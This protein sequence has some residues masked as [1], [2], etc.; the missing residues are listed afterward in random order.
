MSANENTV[1]SGERYVS[2][3]SFLKKFARDLHRVDLN[4]IKR[5][6]KPIENLPRELQYKE[7]SLLCRTKAAI[8]PEWLHL[9]GKIRTRQM[10]ETIAPTFSE[11]TKNLRSILGTEYHNFVMAHAEKLDKMI[12]NEKD[13]GFD[14]FAIEVLLKSYLARI[15]KNGTITIMESPQYMYLRIATFLWF[16]M[17]PDDST[18]ENIQKTYKN[19]SDGNY[20]CASPTMFNTGMSRPQL[21]SCF[22]LTIDDSMKSI[23]KSWHD[24]ATIS[25]HSGGIGIDFTSLRH[26]EIGQHGQTRGIVPWIK[27]QAEILKTVD[28]GG[29]RS[30]SATVYLCDWHLDIEEFLD[31]RKGTGPDS[32]RARNLFYALW[33]SDEFMRRVLEDKEWT[34][35]CPNKVRGLDTKWGNEFEMDYKRYEENATKGKIFHHRVVRARDLW[36][37]IL[38]TQE[39]VGMPFIL[40]KDACNRK[41]NQKN[42]GTIRLSNLCT[43]ILLFTDAENIGSCNLGSVALNKCVKFDADG[44]PYY[45]FDMLEELTRQ[46]VRIVNQIIDRNFYPYEIPE[47]EYTNLRNRPIGIG[48][49]GLA[50]VFA[51]MDM[52]WVD[53]NPK[54]L[55]RRIIETMYYAAVSESV[56]LAEKYGKYDTFDG[57]PASKGFFQFDLWDIEKME[58]EYRSR[59][60][61]TPYITIDFLKD[62]LREVQGPFTKRYDW[63]SLREKMMKSGMRNS[64]LLALMPTASSAT[65]LGNN[66]CFEPYTHQVYARTT[67]SGQF[68]VVNKHLVRDLEKI[69]MWKTKHVRSILSNEGSISQLSEE[70]LDEDRKKRLRFLKRKYMTVFEIPQ[71]IL[72]DMALDRGRMV[73]QTQ[74][75]NCW[76]ADPT[77]EKLNAFHFHGWRNGAKTGMYYL[78]Q[79]ARVDP[80]NFSI[81]SINVEGSSSSSS[82]SRTVICNDDVCIACSS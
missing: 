80:I 11:A 26:S 25:Q 38:L 78:N 16:T 75:F 57:S 20:T 9:A 37:K 22:T 68:L 52:T 14:I 35:F 46:L 48:I 7:L 23:K 61:A 70:G 4:Q 49:Q 65:I 10:K 13:Y 54:E 53:E 76:M 59:S 66:A 55:N 42:L 60:E 81:N 6:L 2:P 72:L 45:D 1:K 74:S 3:V 17:D 5:D 39:E 71:K 24:T 64:L 34:L 19:L 62:H 47:I 67:L 73:C 79:R 63:E 21:A 12:C 31:L 41:S 36:R 82:S 15:K 29:K 51:M 32:Q 69:D 58:R 33:I 8:H 50:D 30:G 27:I 18:F 44:L 56:K 43:E 28:Q 40:Y 77:F